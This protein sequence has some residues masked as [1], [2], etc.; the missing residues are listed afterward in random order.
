MA[1]KI[2]VYNPNKTKDEVREWLLVRKYT[3][4]KEHKHGVILAGDG[5]KSPMGHVAKV[6]SIDSDNKQMVI[7]NKKLSKEQLNN[8]F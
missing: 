8:Y 1:T 6:V 7:S 4:L 2:I 3:H 5:I